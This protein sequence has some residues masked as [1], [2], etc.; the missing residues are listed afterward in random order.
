M[1]SWEVTM[2]SRASWLRNCDGKISLRRIQERRAGVLNA[3]S[4]SKYFQF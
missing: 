3:F 1:R 2:L 4:L